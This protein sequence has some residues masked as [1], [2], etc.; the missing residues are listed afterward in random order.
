MISP[1]PNLQ[2]LLGLFPTPNFNENNPDHCNLLNRSSISTINAAGGLLQNIPPFEKHPYL[3]MVNDNQDV[4]GI[5]IGT[6][7][8]ISYLC[9]TLGLP[10]LNF[11][12]VISPPDIPFFHGNYSSLW[13][14]TPPIIGFGANVTRTANVSAIQNFLFEN[15]ILYTDIIEYCQRKLAIRNG[16]LKYTAEDKLLNNVVINNAVF[17]SLINLE[18]LNRIYFTNASFVGNPNRSNFLF[19]RHGEYILSEKDAFRLFLKGAHDYGFKIDFLNSQNGQWLN[20]NEGYRPVPERQ[21]INNMLTS[22]VI[23]KIRLTFENTQRV[24]Q[25][26]S[27]VSP[28]AVNRGMTRRNNCVLKFAQNNQGIPIGDCPSGL[29]VEVLGSFFDNNTAT[30][31]YNI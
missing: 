23:L 16:V 31:V 21:Q 12:G 3:G 13:N 14:F 5:M 30:A 1:H 11:N 28:A 18:S 4:T 29:L 15:K 8:P 26:F 25:I 27:A 6:F 19:D 7:P 9:D 2:T 20:I 17:E 24:I 10:N 22:K